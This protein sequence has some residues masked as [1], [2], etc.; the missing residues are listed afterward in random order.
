MKVKADKSELDERGETEH[1]TEQ[2]QG[3]ENAKKKKNHI[4]NET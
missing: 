3:K 1:I 4:E 2:Q